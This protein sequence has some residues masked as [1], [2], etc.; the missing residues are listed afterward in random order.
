MR[1]RA[2]RFFVQQLFVTNR[3]WQPCS[4]AG[5]LLQNLR[6]GHVTKHSLKVRIAT[7]I[8]RGMQY[9][10][11]CSPP[12]A[13][14][15]LRSP[16]VFLMHLGH[17]D[18][19]CAKVADFGMTMAASSLLVDPLLTWRWLAPQAYMGTNYDERCDLY[20]FA[21]VMWELSTGREPFQIEIEESGVGVN[22]V[23]R[24]VMEGTL[25]PYVDESALFPELMVAMWAQEPAARPS[26]TEAL[27]HMRHG[28]RLV[29]RNATQ[30]KTDCLVR[31][32]YS[33]DHS[34]MASTCAVG[35][36]PDGSSLVVVCSLDGVVTIFGPGPK[37]F[38][39][40]PTQHPSAVVAACITADGTV[41]SAGGD[42]SVAFCAAEDYMP[43]VVSRAFRTNSS[44]TGSIGGGGGAVGRSRSRG[45]P[46]LPL[47]RN[48]APQQLSDEA[49]HQ[50]PPP[51]SPP[52]SRSPRTRDPP[53]SPRGG[54]SRWSLNSAADNIAA[55]A[56]KGGVL[57]KS[58]GILAGSLRK[59]EGSRTS[60]IDLRRQTS[61]NDMNKADTE[62]GH[63]GA[64]VTA[65]CWQDDD[66]LTA[67][68]TGA[69]IRWR[70]SAGK[71]EPVSNVGVK[72]RW[73]MDR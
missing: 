47:A 63:K 20:S 52:A 29:M 22:E 4:P 32:F 24:A 61:M 73:L 62:V 55:N 10:H 12:L 17:A 15:D 38:A 68:R 9:L 35:P 40:L 42:G 3:W 33:V 41:W 2:R 70:R 16:N 56:E 67:D 6:S 51:K 31:P 60:L 13:H 48:S 5:D 37:L 23:I 19:P 44:S 59:K 11:G 28:K 7:D 45:I 58:L 36:A 8:A 49:P 14:R 30:S 34:A 46:S 21:I 64:A 1:L 26:F 54:T 43:K 27:D 66:V 50:A 18:T 71:G 57:Q 53:K 69:V 65:M 72:A 39:K 25:R